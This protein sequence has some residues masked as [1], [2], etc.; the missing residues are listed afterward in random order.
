MRLVTSRW[1]LFYHIFSLL[2]GRRSVK[3]VFV[4]FLLCTNIQES[5]LHCIIL[6]VQLGTDSNKYFDK[7]ISFAKQIS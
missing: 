2:G 3:A 7:T 1:L 6:F 4:F 5:L